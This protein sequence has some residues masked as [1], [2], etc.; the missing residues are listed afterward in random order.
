MLALPLATALG[1][2]LPAVIVYALCWL[3]SICTGLLFLEIALW[4]PHHA[5][6]VTMARKLLGKW[7]EVAAWALYIFLFYTLTI[8]YVSGGGGMVASLLG[9]PDPM[10]ILLFI[11]FFGLIVFLGPKAVD[12]IN[13]GLMVGLILTYVL[14]ISLGAPHVKWA[15]L[16]RMSFWHA[17]LGLPLL[18]TA[19]SYQGVIPTLMSHLHRNITAM[20]VSIVIGTSIP[21]LTYILWDLLIKGMVA[22]EGPFG[23]VETARL[24]KTA[25]APL[26]H[27]LPDAPVTLIGEFF[28][29]FALTTSFIGV[30]LGLVDF[31]I[32]SLKLPHRGMHRLGVCM[33]VF[34][35]PFAISV[36]NPG[37]FIQALNVAGGYGCALLLGLMPILMVWVGRYHKKWEDQRQLPGGK[38]LLFILTLFIA[39]ELVIGFL[40]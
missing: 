33:F 31:L 24:G 14:F 3:F 26:H 36:S 1:G 6:L 13:L 16:D 29:I 28:A 37:L 38:P 18:F 27:L 40:R 25:I 2:Y 39:F 19:F 12:P 10:A 34:I 23:L 20:R 22:V 21:F 5:N 32:D 15:R 30:T 9:I 17:F 35:P 7:G 4:L 11:L 8:A